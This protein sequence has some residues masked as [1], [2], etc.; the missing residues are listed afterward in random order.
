[1][2]NYIIILFLISCSF[3]SCEEET[4]LPEF[5]E[6]ATMRIQVDPAYS[7]FN[8]AE[9]DEAK[10]VYS[11]FT[12]N[13]NLDR[14]EVYVDYYSFGQDS[15]YD[16]RLWAT[17]T[18]GDF[19]SEGAIREVTITSQEFAEFMGLTVDDLSGG[20]RL[21]FTNFTYLTDGRVFPDTVLKDT[22][23]EAINIE[24]SIVNSA[25]TTSFSVGFTAYIACP[26]TPS[27]WTGEYS[28]AVSNVSSFCSLL[29][30][31]S[32]RD[33]TI[34]FVGTPEPFRYQTSTFDAG[35]WGSFNPDSYDLPGQFYDICGV[36][37]L[38]PSRTGYGDHQDDPNN[39]NPPR[40]PATGV[41]VMNWCN[42]FNPVCGTTTYTPK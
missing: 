20:D 26:T 7:F 35:L 32:T 17:Y 22:D 12:V 13:D 41:I 30:C 10:L 34:T 28:T 40:D 23:Y 19:D 33:A 2:K 42:F 21:D 25:A 11:L 9:I 18:P 14:T 6:G 15:T 8:F 36:P 1:M 39:P 3:L 38:L 4:R 5:E 29:D 27:D 37:L 31:S 24:T 16:T